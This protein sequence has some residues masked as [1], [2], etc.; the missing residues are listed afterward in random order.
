MS[1]HILIDKMLDAIGEYDSLDP[2]GLEALRLITAF[3]LGGAITL[4]E[5]NHYC[6]RQRK[7]VLCAPRR[8]A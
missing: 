1:P 2:T 3:W 4:E 6:A 8:A 7:A 5:F